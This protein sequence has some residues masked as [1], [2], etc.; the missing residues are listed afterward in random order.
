MEKRVSFYDIEDLIER[1]DDENLTFDYPIQRADGQWD[2]SQKALLIDSVLRG[3]LLPQ[4]YIVKEDKED[5]SPMSVL[6]GKQRLTVLRD[7]AQDKFA[8][9]KD[10]KDIVIT[11][12]SFDEENKPIKEEKVY[13]VAGKKFSKL[14]PEL[15]KK[16]KRYK[17]DVVLL[18][19]FTDE[20]IEE[21]FYR[22]NNGCTFTK[23]QKANVKLGTEMAE[24]I[25]EIEQCD[26]FVNRAHFTKTQVKHGEI[27]TCV[28]QTMMLL[29]DFEYK[30]FGGN[31]VLRFTKGLNEN[32]DY[33]LIERTKELYDKLFCVL[34]DY[35][36]ELDKNLKKINIPI[37][38]K[39]M[40]MVDKMETV[41]PDK[42]YEKFLLDWFIEGMICSGYIGYCGQGSTSKEKVRGRIS[43]MREFLDTFVEDLDMS[44]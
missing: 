23:A 33:G 3:Y 37:I 21:Q 27:K 39:N 5:F 44:A 36:K 35:D 2:K 14:D 42:K 31:E 6:D 13:K 29:S 10:M 19:G 12:V 20:E 11:D 22:L 38:I 43:L 15:Q 28:L 25:E 34:P 17:I 24:K 40:D 18:A 9:P 32:P 4:L 8:L 1:M 26:F 41:I 30:N 7:F 16:F